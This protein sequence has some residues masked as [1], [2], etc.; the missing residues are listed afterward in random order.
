MPDSVTSPPWSPG[1]HALPQSQPP[2]PPRWGRAVSLRVTPRICLRSWQLVA[3]P[4]GPRRH[5]RVCG[6]AGGVAW[7]VVS[8]CASR[9]G[10]CL[11]SATRGGLTWLASREFKGDASGC[12]AVW[13]HELS[14]PGA[15]SAPPHPGSAWHG[16]SHPAVG[17][18]AFPAA[19]PVLK[20][21]PYGIQP[22]PSISSLSLF[23]LDFGSSSL[24]NRKTHT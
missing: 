12:S 17:P 16:P 7:R 6:A 19:R 15:V 8:S 5:M 9:S 21:R 20:C 23:F 24:S 18:P 3:S 2:A 10:F 14:R 13:R 22:Q 11:G 1:K 4:H